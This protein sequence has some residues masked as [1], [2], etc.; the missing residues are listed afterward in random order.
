MAEFCIILCLSN[1]FSLEEKWR[2]HPL[3][4]CKKIAL[5][6]QESFTDSQF[7]R[8]STLDSRCNDS[9]KNGSIIKIIAA[10][11]LRSKSKSAESD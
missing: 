6:A 8:L 9:E 10:H 7:Y 2:C 5:I 11:L 1:Y 3:N 4:C